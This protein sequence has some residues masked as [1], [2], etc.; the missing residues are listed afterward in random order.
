M[1]QSMPAIPFCVFATHLLPFAWLAA[2]TSVGLW[3]GLYARVAA[4]QHYRAQSLR[5]SAAR[6]GVR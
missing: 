4:V 1:S 5:G 3:Q 2:G 6:R